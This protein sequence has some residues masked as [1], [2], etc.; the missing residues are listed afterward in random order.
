M[1]YLFR[2]SHHSPAQFRHAFL[3]VDISMFNRKSSF[4]LR[5]GPPTRV[6]ATLAI[7]AK[8]AY[9]SRFPAKM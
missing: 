4:G 5:I 6:P 2:V 3:G 7:V 9:C 8:I 1:W